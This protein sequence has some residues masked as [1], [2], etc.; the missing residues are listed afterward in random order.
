MIKVISPGFYATVQ[1]FG[2][3][4]VQHYGIPYAGVMD[5]KAA[6]LAN[7]ILGNAVDLPVI[8]ITM[9]GPKLQ[10]HCSTT[11]CLSGANMAPK[12]NARKIDNNKIIPIKAGDVLS[13]GKLNSGFRCYLAVWEG[14]RTEKVMESYSMYSGVTNSFK[15]LKNDVLEISNLE[16]DIVSHY[17]AIKVNNDYIS[18]KTI[19]V[20]KGPEFDMLSSLQREQ[21][22]SQEFTISKANNRMAYQLTELIENNLDPILTSAVLPGTIQL[23]P[24]GILIILMRDCQT[25]GGYPRILQL[26]ESALSVLAQKYTNQSIVFKLNRI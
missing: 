13:F 18:S 5:K 8:E 11:L 22:F 4:G 21:L 24:S 9:T 17:A 26:K 16:K 6:S 12:L 20:F 25:T 1:D 23:T 10:F 3:V 2:R 19:A 7:T 14:F 15:L